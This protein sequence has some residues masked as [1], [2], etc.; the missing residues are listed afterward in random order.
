MEKQILRKVYL[1]VP[2][3]EDDQFDARDFKSDFNCNTSIDR[4]YESDDDESDKD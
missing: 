1:T 4:W 2:K 3:L